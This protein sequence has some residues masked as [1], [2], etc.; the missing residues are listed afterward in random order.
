[1]SGFFLKMRGFSSPESGTDLAIHRHIAVE[2]GGDNDL[3]VYLIG[4]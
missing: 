1:M 3:L 2:L 4:K